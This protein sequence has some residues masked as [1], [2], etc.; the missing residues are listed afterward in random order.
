MP[1]PGCSCWET[2]GW[3]D[4]GIT[5]VQALV[6]EGAVFVDGFYADSPVPHVAAF[7]NGFSRPATTPFPIC[8]RRRPTTPC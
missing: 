1:G 4:P 8:W 7:V 6:V 5:D 3:N 2:D